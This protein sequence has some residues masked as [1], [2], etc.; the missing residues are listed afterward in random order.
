MNHCNVCVAD[1]AILDV[2]TTVVVAQK[3]IGPLAVTTGAGLAVTFIALLVFVQFPI[4]LTTVYAPVP[5]AAVLVTVNVVAFAFAIAIPFFIHCN[6]TVDEAATLEV[7]TTVDVPH[8]VVLVVV[9][10]TGFAG[11]VPVTFQAQ[12]VV[13]KV[14]VS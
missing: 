3:V 8:N 10:T 5:N 12:V 1:G 9:D 13:L 6:D 4:V 11:C 14:A 7:K 2:N